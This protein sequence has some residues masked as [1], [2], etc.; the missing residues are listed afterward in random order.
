VKQ[1][2]IFFSS[3]IT[4]LSG[5]NAQGKTNVIEA[6]SVLASLRSFRTR[7][8]VDLILEGKQTAEIEGEIQGAGFT[9]S[10]HVSVDRSGKTARLDG[11]T[12]TSAQEYLSTLQ[13]V[14]FT[15]WDLELS[16]GSQEMRR[17]Y[18]DRAAFLKD[19]G[20][21]ALLRRY[22]KILRHRNALLRCVGS[23]LS[24]W[25]D[26][27][28][29]VGASIRRARLG[30]LREI[31]PIL[32][33]VQREVSGGGE[34]VEIKGEGIWG[35]DESSALDLLKEL[36][37]AEEVDRRVGHSTVGP[38]RD[39][40]GIRLCGRDTRSR[41]SRGQHR[42]VALSLKIALA[43]WAAKTLGE[44]PVLLLDDPASE[45][46]AQRIFF[47]GSFLSRW[48]GQSIIACTPE[49][50]LSFDSGV[51]PFIYRVSAGTI[52]PWA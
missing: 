40:L 6:V 31:R 3:G 38:H 24:V 5:D 46:D 29:E 19:V 37:A 28:A 15:P 42:T 35:T 33:E 20:H 4:V 32:D 39:S 25:N 11:R 44:P 13:T 8:I 10:L 14:L 26:Q 17:S 21:L 2:D 22:G 18:V 23:D 7:K 41:A 1:A 36:K 27:L 45:L 51:S 43:V 50:N 47:I 34:D 52:Q 9:S 16:L 12:P 48:Q 30:V 49:A